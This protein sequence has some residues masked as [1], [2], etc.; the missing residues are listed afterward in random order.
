MKSRY[1]LVSVGGGVLFGVMDALFNANPLAQKL[2]IVFEPIARKSVDIPT[3]IAIDL[4]YGFAM[5]GIFLLLYQSLPGKSKIIK[6]L[7]FGLLGWFFRVVMQVASQWMMFVI[8]P[9]TLV[10][11]LVCGFIEMLVLGLFYGLLLKPSMK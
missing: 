3:G 5:G 2:F 1:I 10:Y 11:L 6:G 7:G 8:P 9:S 4:I